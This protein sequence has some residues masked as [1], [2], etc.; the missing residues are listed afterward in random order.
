M[1]DL[2]P[3]FLLSMPRSGSTLLQRVLAAHSAIST[4]SEP[5]LL[6]PLLY[7]LRAQGTYSDY[8]HAASVEAI[9]DF[10]NRLPSGRSDY[11]AEI[12]AMAVRVYGKASVPG[13]RY[14]LDKTPRYNLVAEELFETFPNAS[15]VVLWRNPLSVVS[16][17]MRTWLDGRWMPSVFK[18]DLYDGLER[19]IA[20]LAHHPGRYVAVRYE[21]FV[22]NP[23]R[24][25]ERILSYL[26]LPWEPDI[27][28]RFGDVRLDGRFG[29]RVGQ[30]KYRSIS[31]GSVDTWKKDFSSPVRLYWARRYITWIGHD[32]LK[33][34]G[35]DI[36]HLRSEMRTAGAD[37]SRVP[38]DAVSGLRGAVR[39]LVEPPLMR[40]KWRAMSHLHRVHTHT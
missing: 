25:V 29:D 4:S 3:L 26:G 2:R 34:M 35:Y 36:D 18:V 5:W 12:A 11:L 37:W 31:D 13:S 8:G 9:E 27:L 23:R 19:L 16:S 17:C 10:Y 32:R 21:D 38:H 6:L 30:K 14:Y 22:G 7:S 33:F 1:S 24:E 40:E 20:A 28:D 15:V 39:D